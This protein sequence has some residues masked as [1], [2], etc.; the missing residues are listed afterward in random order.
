MLVGLALSLAGSVIEY[1]STQRSEEDFSHF[2]S[3][4]DTRAERELAE[5]LQVTGMVA[6]FGGA[7][8]GLG[9]W[10]W[11]GEHELIETPPVGRGDSGRRE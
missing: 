4:R 1:K 7:M 11:L 8:L 2:P 3:T 10:W 6:V 9:L 5:F